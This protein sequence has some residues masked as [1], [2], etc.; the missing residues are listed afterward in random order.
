MSPSRS[1]DPSAGKRRTSE[2]A[3]ITPTY[4][5]RNDGNTRLAYTEAPHNE[6]ASTATDF[7][8]NACVSS[9]ALGIIRIKRVIAHSGLGYRAIDFTTSLRTLNTTDPPYTPP[10]NA[11]VELYNHTLA[12]NYCTL[13][14]HQP[15]ATEHR[16]DDRL[17]LIAATV[18]P[19]VRSSYN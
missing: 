10:H 15:A 14:E 12:E 6:T 2:P 13:A 5:P 7:I 4:F 11:K 17:R 3:P 8:G 16:E 1:I 18:S 9:A 19:N